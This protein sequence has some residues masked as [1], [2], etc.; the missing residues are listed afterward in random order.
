MDEGCGGGHHGPIPKK[1]IISIL[2]DWRER[3]KD[4]AWMHA[5]SSRYYSTVN[6]ALSM[7]VVL[8]SAFAG[9]ANFVLVASSPRDETKG[10]K[11]VQALV[12]VVSV[13]AAFLSGVQKMTKVAELHEAHNIFASE[14]E[15][16][17]REIRVEALLTDTD[18]TTYADHAVLL[19]QCQE[20]FDR[21]S[22]K[23]PSVPSHIEGLLER[24]KSERNRTSR[25]VMDVPV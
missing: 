16:L 12:G 15:K 14:F 19:R 5:R 21:L 18:G 6:Y 2:R 10:P 20:E 22:D 4:S 9:A 1:E 8:F 11:V 25:E 3:A 17:A 24:K 23:A 7:P 13:A